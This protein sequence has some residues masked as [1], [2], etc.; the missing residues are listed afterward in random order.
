MV[1]IRGAVF[2]LM[3]FSFG[4]T[5]ISHGIEF[6]VVVLLLVLAHVRNIVIDFYDAKCNRKFST[7]KIFVF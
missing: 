6:V 7:P 4:L 2:F 5:R 3:G 1:N